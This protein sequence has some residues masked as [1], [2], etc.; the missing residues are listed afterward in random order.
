MPNLLIELGTEELPVD[1]LDVIYSDLANK[2]QEALKSNRLAHG[3]VAV[4]ATPR[5]IALYIE[6]LANRQEDQ[7]LEFSGPSFEKAYDATGNPTPALQG[8]LK[9]KG[10]S[11]KDLIIKETPK[12]KYVVV[13]KNE[14]GQ[15]LTAVL[16][17]LLAGIFTSLAFPKMMRWPASPEL[18][19]GEEKSNFRFPRP[20][21]WV[22]ALLDK[23]VLAFRI[24]ELKSGNRSFGHRFLAPKSFSI[25]S[26]DWDTYTKI[27][28]RNH[29]ILALEE[30][31]NLIRKG[32]KSFRQNEFDEDLV[33]FTASLVEE[34]FLMQGGFSKSYLELPSEVLASCMKKNQKIFACYDS[35]GKLLNRFVAILNGKRKGLSGIRAG[36]ENVLDSRLKDAKYFYNADTKEPLEKKLN[37]L[38]QVTYLGKLG[39]MKEKTARV[40][41]LSFKLGQWT[42]SCDP[43]DAARAAHLSKIDLMTHLVY[44]FPDLQG[45]VGGNYAAASGEKQEVAK[46]ISTQ[47]LPKTLSEN[48]ESL[49]EKMNELGAVIGIADRFDHLVGAIG[50]GVQF[51]GSQD[52]FGLRR[53]A[54]AIAKIIRAFKLRFSL[55]ECIEKSMGLY[56]NRLNVSAGEITQKLIKILEERIEFELQIKSGTRHQEI[57]AAVVKSNFDDIADVFNRY[58]ILSTLYEKDKDTFLKAAKVVERT[59]NIL[60]GAKAAS[61]ID[62]ELLKEK[63]EKKLYELLEARSAEVSEHVKKKEYEKATSKFGEIFYNPINEFFEQVMVN[64]EDQAIRS[65]RQALMSRINRLYTEHLA[66][67]SVLSKLDQG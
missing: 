60:K 15:P 58:E 32:L 48:F 46:A 51:S 22:V 49:R 31:K 5:R 4:E 33:H 30:R 23:K 25:P 10:A 29:V 61:H 6:G 1:A 64:V 45:I 28:K 21:R 50:T 63:S 17:S 54:G 47:Y 27:L 12:G 36:Y 41:S 16:P 13:K 26:A 7:D 20:I 3:K 43:D 9:G 14:K 53:A 18:Q 19:R 57:L 59:S 35:K 24:A 11:L 40:Q 39:N 8:F 65:N 62:S 44:E 56:E 55:R 42:K 2:T 67:L 37:L 66:D 34:P 38:E 52:P